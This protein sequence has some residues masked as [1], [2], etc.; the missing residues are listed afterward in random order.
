MII[1]NWIVWS[2]A[3]ES[4]KPLIILGC[5]LT[6]VGCFKEFYNFVKVFRCSMVTD[7]ISEIFF[8]SA[9]SSFLVI[10][11]GCFVDFSILKADF[12]SLLFDAFKSF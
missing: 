2:T 3:F 9:V 1:Y 10:V 6:T 4:V 8:F 11:F 5:W 12:M 7:F